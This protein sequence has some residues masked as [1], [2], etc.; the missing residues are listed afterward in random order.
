MMHIPMKLTLW[1]W[2]DFRLKQILSLLITLLCKIVPMN[3]MKPLQNHS[4]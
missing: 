1:N 3:C 2:Y 4:K